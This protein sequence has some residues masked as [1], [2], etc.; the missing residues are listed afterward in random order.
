MDFRLC[1]VLRLNEVIAHR[2][3]SMLRQ[4]AIV[5][6]GRSNGNA[7]AG[8]A[9]RA[10]YAEAES[11]LHHHCRTIARTRHSDAISTSGNEADPYI[12][13]DES[14]I[15]FSSVRAGGL[16]EGDLY[17]SFNQ[18]GKWTAPRSLGPTVNT[19]DYEYTPLVSPDKK[20]FF[21]SRGWGDI[22]QVE[23]GALQL[24]P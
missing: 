11:R 1:L 21:F 6:R 13:P 22:Y 20:H 10:P 9:L 23:L 15:I 3:K 4:S 7:L 17:I 16:G 8:F 14:Y 12:A 5:N 19:S 24:K 2:L 18:K